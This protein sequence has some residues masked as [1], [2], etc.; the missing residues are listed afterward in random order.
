MPEKFRESEIPGVKTS[1]GQADH[2]EHNKI[3]NLLAAALDV[4][5]APAVKPA[6]CDPP[7]ADNSLSLEQ[8][9]KRWDVVFE[10]SD[11]RLWALELKKCVLEDGRELHDL[12]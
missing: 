9:G 2:E 10:D 6:E 7:F 12:E 1:I 8:R 11:G 3:V 4:G 5:G